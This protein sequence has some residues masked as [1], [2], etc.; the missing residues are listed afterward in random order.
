M[1]KGWG[2]SNWKAVPKSLTWSHVPF[3]VTEVLTGKCP[4]LLI[5]DHSSC[6][7]N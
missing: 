3:W 7:G 4:T 6:D 5:P 2:E 1:A